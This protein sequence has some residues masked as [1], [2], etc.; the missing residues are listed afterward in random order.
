[1]ALLDET[2]IKQALKRLGEL[3]EQ[4]G[5]TIELIVVGGAVM[6]LVYNA[7]QATHDIDAIILSP[8]E[9][10]K[11][12]ELAVN[13]AQELN[14][15]QD[16]LNDG[17][18]GYFIGIS[19]GNTLLRSPGIIVRSPSVTQ[20]LAMKLSAWRDDV[21]ISDA[22]RLLQE[23]KGT[24]AEIWSEIIPFLLPGRELKAQYAFMDLWETLY[25]EN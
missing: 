8:K 15:H 19:Q 5:E 1:V 9:V 10:I 2:Q 24:Q 20:L 18:K 3:A 17:A 22:R 13:V 16:W 21:D 11:V 7:R 14:L 6:V 4:N 12:R 25:G 23:L